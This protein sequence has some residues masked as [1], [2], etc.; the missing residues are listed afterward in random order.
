MSIKYI[1]LLVLAV[2][3]SALILSMRYSRTI[4]GPRYNPT[5]T[6]LL[7]EMIK[8]V[9]SMIILLFTRWRSRK[10][11]GT[12]TS[13]EGSGRSILRESLDDILQSNAII[14]IMIPA[15]LYTIQNNLQYLAASNLDAGTFQVLYQGKILTTAFF[16]VL[17]LRQK[18]TVVKWSAILILTVGI[19]FVSYPSSAL[20]KVVRSDIAAD[21]RMIGLLAVLSA[22]VL[23]GFAGVFLEF[24]L[25]KA[26]NGNSKGGSSQ[27]WTRNVQLSLASV[28]IAALATAYVDGAQ[29]L[30]DG[31]F[32]GYNVTTWCTLLLQAFGGLIVA[33]VIT[34]ADNILKGFATSISLIISTVV[35][36]MTGD[37]VLT[38]RFVIGCVL[39]LAATNIY[40]I[41]WEKKK[42]P[43]EAHEETAEDASPL[44][45]ENSEDRDFDE[46]FDEKDLEMKLDQESEEKERPSSERRDTETG[47]TAQPKAQE[48][49]SENLLA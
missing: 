35:S 49:P 22:C 1:S 13:E 10:E 47:V 45:K 12:A 31:F 19:V 29:I 39:V 40:G 42:R 20:K 43:Q 34:Y 6:V 5:T 30:R 14:P 2:Q 16:A 23:S 24:I 46:D 3:N 15:I 18:L 48:I 44:L 9:F 4:P 38:E 11:P 25:K 7:S 21:Q 33:I 26:K 41:S 27:L 32:Y 28:G 37:M 36:T 17:I 8:T